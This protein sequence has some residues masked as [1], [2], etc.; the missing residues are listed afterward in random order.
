MAINTKGHM[1]EIYDW[2]HTMYEVRHDELCRHI[3][4]KLI[5]LFFE[6]LSRVV[7]YLKI[8]VRKYVKF[9]LYRTH[10]MS[11]VR[12]FWNISFIQSF[13][14]YACQRKCFQYLETQVLLLFACTKIIQGAQNFGSNFEIFETQ[15]HFFLMIMGMIFILVQKFE[16]R[17]SSKSHR[18][19]WIYLN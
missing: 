5:R 11:N 6:N 4:L 1:T 17:E 10:C 2:R 7:K 12:H 19:M 9:E 18:F 15:K 13:Y 16:S 8:S 14:M 3:Y